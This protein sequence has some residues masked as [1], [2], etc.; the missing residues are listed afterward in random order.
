MAEIHEALAKIHLF[1]GLSD[2]GLRRIAEIA[3][4]ESHA[5]NSLI[6]KEGDM[7]DK[8]YMI[9]DG[10]VRIS[11]EVAGMGEEALTVLGP[12][13]AFGEMSV[14]D[15]FPRSAD[16]RVHEK[17][18]VLVISRDAMEDLLF[19]HKDLAYEILWNFVKILSARLRETNDKMTFLST[20]GKF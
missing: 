6:F 1:R 19:V 5:R 10:K 8:L 4:E 15:D 16:A 13:D 2:E 3:V 9:L 14:V 11:R 12:G 17:C 20:S 7:G 18:R